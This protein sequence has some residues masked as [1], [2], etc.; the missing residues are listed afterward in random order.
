MRIRT[1]AFAVLVAATVPLLS[2][3]SAGAAG[4]GAVSFT[5][6]LRNVVIFSDPDVNPCTGDP[7]TVTGT[8]KTGVFHITTLTND[9][10]HATMTAQGTITFVPDDPADPSA[11]G[12]FTAWFGDNMNRQNGAA[13]STF[14]AILSGSDGSR[15]ATHE[16]FHISTSA[17]GGSIEFDKPHL[18]CG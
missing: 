5:E 14:H 12:R 6:Q 1:G 16:V 7:G 18:T 11:S 15:V 10:V 17:S 13:T 4:A 9:T 2:A 3:A 8:A